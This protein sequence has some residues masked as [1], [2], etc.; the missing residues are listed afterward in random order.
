[1]HKYISVLFAGAVVLL[2][3]PLAAFAQE[4]EAPEPEIHPITF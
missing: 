4:E 3:T 2:M 1:M